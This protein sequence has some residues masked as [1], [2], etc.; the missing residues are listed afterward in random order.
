MIHVEE[1]FMFEML[2]H[3]YHYSIAVQTVVTYTG[4]ED[5]D[6]LLRTLII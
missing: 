4:Q 6:A 3:A 2:M 1:M 5:I